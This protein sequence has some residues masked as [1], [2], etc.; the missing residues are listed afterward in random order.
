MRPRLRLIVAS[1]LLPG[2]AIRVG[3]TGQARP[4]EEPRPVEKAMTRSRTLLLSMCLGLLG[5]SLLLTSSARAV[6]GVRWF[7]IG[8]A[9]GP[10]L[11]PGSASGRVTAIAVNPVN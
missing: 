11:F 4:G 7:P 10:G 1:I 8:P 3:G 6:T 9:P 5:I 2:A